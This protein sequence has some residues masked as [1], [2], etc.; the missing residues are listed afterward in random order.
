MKNE[1]TY[2]NGDVLQ[3]KR[4]PEVRRVVLKARKSSCLWFYPDSPPLTD[5]DLISKVYD[6]RNSNDSCMVLGWD[7]VGV[8]DLKEIKNISR[9]KTIV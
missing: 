4:N 7:K 5:D 3:M 1:F 2:K 6:S 8:C 9:R